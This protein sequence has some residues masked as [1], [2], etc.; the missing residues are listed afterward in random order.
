MLR[1]PNN[2]VGAAAST[3]APSAE[4][5]GSKHALEQGRL[6]VTQDLSAPLEL[7]GYPV[8][9]HHASLAHEWSV[10]MPGIMSSPECDKRPGWRHLCNHV[11]EITRRSKQS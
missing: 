7:R 9:L 10:S 4:R 6:V 11:I 5:Y 2:Q 1:H 3:D 8:Q